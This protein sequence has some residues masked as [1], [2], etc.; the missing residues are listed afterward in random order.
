MK[1]IVISISLILFLTSCNTKTS[2]SKDFLI[3]SGK[4]CGV[5]S[6]TQNNCI[7]FLPT[8]IRPSDEGEEKFISVKYEKANDSMI[9]IYNLDDG[10]K[11]EIYLKSK[12]TIE[13]GENNELIFS[14]NGYTS[15][16]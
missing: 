5:Y 9:Y 8:G 10:K 16:E 14:T 15:P 2:I 1:K 11:T 7:E 13:L 3:S 12:D 4:W 6:N